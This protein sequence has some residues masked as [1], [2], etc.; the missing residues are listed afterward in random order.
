[1]GT[2]QNRYIFLSTLTVLF[3]AAICIYSLFSSYYSEINSH[4]RILLGR[5]QT[6]IDALKAGILAHGRM[7]RY[8]GDRLSVI[9]EE[10]AQNTDILALELRDPNGAILALGGQRG[11]I[12][13]VPPPQPG[14]DSNKLV[15]ATHVNFLEECSLGGGRHDSGTVAEV[16]TWVPFSKGNYVLIAV[17]DASDV[18]WAI[19]RHHFQFVISLGIISAALISG[20]AVVTLLL[21][22]T[23]LAGLLERERERASRQE[24][25]ALLGAGLAHETKNPLG[26]IRA[27]A[28]SIN[29]CSKHT[30][31][32]KEHSRRIVDEVDRVIGGINSFLVLSRPQEAALG[33]VPLDPFF[34]EFLSLVQMDAAAASVDV[35]FTP[36]ECTILADADLLRRALLNLILNALYASEPGQTVVLDTKRNNGSLSLRVTDMGKGIAPEDMPHILEPYFTRSGGGSGLGL[37]IV[38]QIASAHGWRLKITSTPGQ[39]TRASLENIHIVE[40]P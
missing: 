2:K 27:V 23:E 18:H 13:D 5:G 4:R 10:L 24:R 17:L 22:K 32:I 39:G 12:P 28:Q 31:P 19:R 3:I 30:C 16:E 40:A 38:E 37:S 36:C 9:F 8:R 33:N 14:W 1:M 35:S 15:L 11:Q 34:K 6:I 25:L 7:G 20:I 21:K 26:S 29:S